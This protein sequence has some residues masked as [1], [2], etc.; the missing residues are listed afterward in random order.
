MVGELCV[1]ARVNSQYMHMGKLRKETKLAIMLG[2]FGIYP[3]YIHIRKVPSDY[4]VL[5]PTSRMLLLP[6]T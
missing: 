2:W 1:I 4:C 3:Y 6:V 5:L